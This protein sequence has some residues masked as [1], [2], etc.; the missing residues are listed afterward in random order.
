MNQKD[1]DQAVSTFTAD[2]A[3]YPDNVEGLVN[4]LRH[5]MGS[6]EFGV[7]TDAAEKAIAK[8]QGDVK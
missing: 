8:A 4:A 2:V 5:K 6:V 1:F 7:S 3:K